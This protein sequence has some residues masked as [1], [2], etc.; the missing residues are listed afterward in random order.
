MGA[1]SPGD[2]AFHLPRQDV[3][4]RNQIEGSVADPALAL[5]GSIGSIQDMSV[6][7]FF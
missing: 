1:N 2:D 3:C 4:V 7:S 5:L 6:I